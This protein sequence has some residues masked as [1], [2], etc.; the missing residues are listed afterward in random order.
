MWCNA[1][2]LVQKTDGR[3]HF[4]IDFCHLNACTK[5]GL[6]PIAKNPRSTWKFGWYWPF[7]MPGPEVWILANQDGLAVEAVHCIYCWLP[8]LLWVWLH[9]FW[10]VQCASHVPEV[11]AKLPWE[12]NLTYCLINLN[13]IIIF[14]QTAEKHLHCLCIIF[15]QFREH[16]L[17][18]KL[19]K[20]N[21][22][23]N[24]ITYLAHWVSKERVY[25]SNSNLKAIAECALPQNYT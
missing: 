13:D 4:C 14:S 24:E 10:A 20:C 18:L 21:F 2:V 8:G 6:L 16:N 25:P 17:K 12:L 7:L 11:N 1:V 19:S 5:E 9:A 22:F 15:D 3:L 23:R